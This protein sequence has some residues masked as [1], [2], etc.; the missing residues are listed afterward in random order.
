VSVIVHQ[1]KEPGIPLPIVDTHGLT[2][3]EREVTGLVLRGCSTHEIASSLHLSPYTVQDHLKAVFTK[4]RVRS[5]RELVAKVFAQHYAP[6]LELGNRIGPMA[7]SPTERVS[8]G[9]WYPAVAAPVDVR[10]SAA[11]GPWRELEPKR[12]QN[13]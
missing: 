10:Q 4:L 2:A 9:G 3:R 6:R 8:R 5:R 11:S 12:C 7:G 13:A 1:L